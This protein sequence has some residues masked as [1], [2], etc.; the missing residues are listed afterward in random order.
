MS[1]I[2]HRA[3]IAGSSG[4][5]IV[6]PTS[7]PN[8]G[9][10]QG[11]PSRP[12]EEDPMRRI[13]I[14]LTTAL[15]GSIVAAGTVAAGGPPGVG[16]YVDGHL[17]RTVGTP[18]DFSGTGAP[19]HSYDRIFVLGGDLTNVAEAKPGD[20]DFNGGR[21]MVTPVDWKAVTPTQVT[22]ADELIAM[23]AE[24]LIA[25]GDPVKYFECPVIPLPG[26]ER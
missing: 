10:A 22:D 26:N 3:A 20:R 16:F 12:I 18:T 8:A 23:E 15:L 11:P 13:G 6:A 2:R 5:V 21:W 14:A 24:G 19:A 7:G 4:L 9:R 17:Y 1:R 25:F